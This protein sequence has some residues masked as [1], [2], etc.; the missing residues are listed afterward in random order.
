VENY[1]HA[2]RVSSTAFLRQG[3]PNNLFKREYPGI[4]K[5]GFYTKPLVPCTN[6]AEIP[7]AEKHHLKLIYKD[8][9]VGLFTSS[10][11]NQKTGEVYHFI[12]KEKI[13]GTICPM[14]NQDGSQNDDGQYLAIFKEPRLPNDPTLIGI[15]SAYQPYCDR[16]EDVI[17]MLSYS[18]ASKSF[19]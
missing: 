5:P 17:V 9:V 1:S 18:S 4:I 13:D 8:M 14:F 11:R 19:Y 10:P 16:H 6:T 7:T 2:S 3:R 12:S 15:K